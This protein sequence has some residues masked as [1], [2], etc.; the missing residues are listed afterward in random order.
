MRFPDFFLDNKGDLLPGAED[1]G[2]GQQ[3]PL[4]KT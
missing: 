4:I 3:I 2:K 1:S